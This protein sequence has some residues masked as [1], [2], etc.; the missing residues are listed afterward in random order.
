MADVRVGGAYVDFT[1]RNRRF[2]TEVRRNGQALRRQQRQVAALRRAAQ[3]FNRTAQAFVRRQLS[4]RRVVAVVAGATGLG[5]LIKRHVDLGDELIKSARASGLSARAYQ[6]YRFAADLAG[7]S[8]DK[9]S[10]AVNG[11]RTRVGEAQADTGELVTVLRR[12][13]P[14][15]LRLVQ[16]ARS[17]DEAFDLILRA[18]QRLENP[19]QRAALLG[20]AFGRRVGPAMENLLPTLD[21][22][23]TRFRQLG[24]AIDENKLS[25]IEVLRDRMTELATVFSTIVTRAVADNADALIRLI[26]VIINRLPGAIETGINL[27]QRLSTALTEERIQIGRLN[28]DRG[29]LREQQRADLE[30]VA[31]LQRSIAGEQAR[32]DRMQHERARRFSQIR[33][34]L[35]QKELRQAQQNVAETERLLRQNTERVASLEN[36][37]AP[38]RTPAAAGPQTPTTPSTPPPPTIQVDL[39]TAEMT[40]IRQRQI[41]FERQIQD[42][43]A[44]QVERERGGAA[45]ERIRQR[46]IMLSR[47]LADAERALATTR[48][49]GSI[50]E[51]AAAERRV[52]A[53]EQEHA[54]FLERRSLLQQEALVIDAGTEAQARY[55][56]QLATLTELLGGD[57]AEANRIYQVHVK[58]L[59]AEFRAGIITIYEYEAAVQSLEDHL[60]EL[61]DEQRQAEDLAEDFGQ[62]VGSFARSVIRD[63]DSVGEAFRNLVLRIADAVLELLVIQP[64]IRA[65]KTGFYSLFG[66]AFQHGGTFRGGRPILVGEAG[67]EII[68]PTSSG[69]VIP[70]DE[71]VG[72]ASDRTASG[73]VI[74]VNVNV[75]GDVTAATRRV[76]RQDIPEIA[77]GVYSQFREGGVLP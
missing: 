14:E 52:M 70:N 6:E 17:T 74:N 43:R 46:E 7:I 29:H 67:P 38:R 56:E 72:I 36:R 41:N 50:T 19:L 4:I 20:A 24:L 33:I 39:T 60:R 23:I 75:T 35:M 9:F 76:L 11:F 2:I 27:F 58:D 63:V 32:A 66:G 54:L 59:D 21:Q 77:A 1:A 44:L 15:L 37:L 69:R 30:R 49:V 64:I 25:R 28:L 26:D 34:R 57:A 48:E 55:E 68:Y 53:A 13:D 62:A 40:A 47:Q 73:P 8:T 10:R 45:L 5:L 3:S 42:E 12:M 18:A 31:E 22:S 71:L 65:V 61:S 51:Q 16:S